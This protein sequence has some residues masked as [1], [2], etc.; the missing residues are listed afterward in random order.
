MMTEDRN[1][2]KH[3]GAEKLVEPVEAIK[4]NDLSTSWCLGTEIADAG[5]QNLA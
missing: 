1:P 5:R 2:I 4:Q 3:Q